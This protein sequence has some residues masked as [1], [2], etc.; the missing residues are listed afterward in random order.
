MPDAGKSSFKAIAGAAFGAA[1]QRCMALSVCIIVGEEDRI[2]EIIKAAE[3]LNVGNGFDESADVS[4]L[5]E[6]MHTA[7]R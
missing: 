3:E 5:S 6:S 7:D 2:P 1:G 4:V